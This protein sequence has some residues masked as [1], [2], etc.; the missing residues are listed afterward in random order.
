[1]KKGYIISLLVIG[2]LIVLSVGLLMKDLTN[3][4]LSE[5]L[6]PNDNVSTKKEEKKTE[7]KKEETPS[8]EPVQLEASDPEAKTTNITITNKQD[9]N[10][11]VNY[12]YQIKISGVSGSI[13]TV[14]NNEREYLVFDARGNTTFNLLNNESI[15]F[16]GVPV[17]ETYTITQEVKNGYRTFSNGT[18][19]V[20]TSGTINNE[21]IITFTNT[22][23]GKAAAPT[24]T[25][26]EVE[27]DVKNTV[28][29]DKGMIAVVIS[30]VALFTLILLKALRLDRYEEL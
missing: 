2:L 18:E 22:S 21:N 19:S 6:K 3:R 20:T 13:L 25:P 24:P 7:E 4:D 29:S 17:N 5:N 23:K 15:T 16:V 14:K 27:S 9:N 8:V 26:V 28:T 10:E 12:S 30:L 1:M 11:I